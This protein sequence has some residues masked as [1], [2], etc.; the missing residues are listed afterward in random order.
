MSDIG[1]TLTQ[2][3]YTNRAF[4]RNPASAFFTF[5]FPLIFL[6][7]FTTL[8]GGD[9]L[10]FGP[11]GGGGELEMKQSTY[12]VVAI[13][14][15]GI[16]SACYTNIAISTTFSRD[17]GI[18]KRTRG[19][20]LPDWV[21]LAARVIHATFIGIVLVVITAAFGAFAYDAGLPTGIPL[22]EFAAILVI[23]SL[24]FSA[25]ALALT[26]V[27]PN[28]DASPAIVNASMLPLLFLSGVFIPF[29]NDTPQWLET[30]GGIFPVK[31]FLHAMLGG[32]LGNVTVSTPAG[33]FRVFPF[34]WMDVVV[35]A[36]WGF[37]GL[38]LAVRFFSWEPRR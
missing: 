29:D 14:V 28:A 8:L 23:G 5:A 4:W 26:A 20:P 7:I 11:P 25:L 31:P 32:Y 21:Y 34:D 19:T 18:L 17:A 2:V 15:F 36:V 13:M 3:R 16:I 30:L 22:L 12:Y 6:V 9:E 24:S 1:L 33:P 35:V 38:I 37:A 10:T 27:I